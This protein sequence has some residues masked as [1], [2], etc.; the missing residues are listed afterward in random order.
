RPAG[1]DE[2]MTQLKARNKRLPRVYVYCDEC[3]YEIGKHYQELSLGS[4][5]YFC[6]DDNVD[7]CCDII[8]SPHGCR[9]KLQHIYKQKYYDLLET[10]E[11]RQL[12]WM[13]TKRVEKEEL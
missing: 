5:G 4:G 2:L 3:T 10:G 13:D 9:E 1:F 7:D 12:S 6:M 11:V 8:N